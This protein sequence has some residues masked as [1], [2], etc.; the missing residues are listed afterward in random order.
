MRHTEPSL[1]KAHGNND[2]LLVHGL[3]GWHTRFAIKSLVFALNLRPHKP[4]IYAFS[5]KWQTNEPA[6]YKL[7]RLES[8]WEQKRR[9]ATLV[10]ISAGANPVRYLALTQPN[11]QTKLHLVAGY[12]GDGSDISSRHRSEAPE[13]A[14]V[15][16]ITH[17]QLRN[18]LERTE[19]IRLHL[20]Q[21]DDV[22]AE[23]NLHISGALQELIPREGHANAI[24][25]WLIHKLPRLAS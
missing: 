17:G 19:A 18:T 13:F 2:I 20:P 16:E 14:A 12:C 25:W 23:H 24:A 7:E 21:H 6:R 9:P 4:K 15:S 22:I 8:Y 3:G 11:V 1:D 10:G 5:P